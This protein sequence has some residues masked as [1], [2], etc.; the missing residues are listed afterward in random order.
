MSVSCSQDGARMAN[1]NPSSPSCV[2]FEW[3]HCVTFGASLDG[4]VVR[5]MTVTFITVH[6]K[7][8]SE[9][10]KETSRIGCNKA[11]RRPLDI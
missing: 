11:K 2:P 3:L 8:R 5:T 4:D 10:T 9:G 7:T 6:Y 1:D